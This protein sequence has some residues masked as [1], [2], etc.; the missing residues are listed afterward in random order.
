MSQRPV[1]VL[2]FRN[3]DDELKFKADYPDVL[4]KLRSMAAE[5]GAAPKE[6]KIQLPPS[7]LDPLYSKEG[8]EGVPRRYIVF[9]KGS[10]MLPGGIISYY[11][12]RYDEE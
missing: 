9:D 12:L 2:V 8:E 3:R 4:P 1:P 11:F 6:L 5:E 7:K 10:D